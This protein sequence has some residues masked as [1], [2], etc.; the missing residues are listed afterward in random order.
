[1]QI[2]YPTHLLV[3]MIATFVTKAGQVWL[4]QELQAEKLGQHKTWISC[5][6]VQQEMERAFTPMSENEHARHKLLEIRIKATSLRS[7][8]GSGH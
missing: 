8:R 1:M 3:D 2:N 5:A 7:S 4:V 6:E